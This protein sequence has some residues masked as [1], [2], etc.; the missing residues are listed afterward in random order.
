MQATM[1]YTLRDITAS[2]SGINQWYLILSR[3]ISGGQMRELFQRSQILGVR[4][5]KQIN[6]T[7]IKLTL[8]KHDGPELITRLKQ[9]LFFQFKVNKMFSS[10]LVMA[11]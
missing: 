1:H 5:L 11:Q 4:L 8:L 10:F 2:W 3:A 9:S 7:C 6:D